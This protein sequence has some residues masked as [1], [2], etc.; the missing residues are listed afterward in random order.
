MILLFLY[1]EAE[2]HC[3]ALAGLELI[4]NHRLL[5][6]GINSVCHHTWL[7][8]TNTPESK[9]IRVVV[10]PGRHGVRRS[11]ERTASGSWFFSSTL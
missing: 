9:H 1:F 5:S 7:L 8:C 3:V 6:T 10:Q 2:A 4:E 11:E